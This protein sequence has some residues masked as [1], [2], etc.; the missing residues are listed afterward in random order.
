MRAASLSDTWLLSGRD[1]RKQDHN[2]CKG[3][4][5]KTNRWAK[6][7]PANSAELKEHYADR[8]F[9]EDGLGFDDNQ[10]EAR[11]VGAL[12]RFARLDRICPSMSRS[13]AL[14][15]GTSIRADNISQAA[16]SVAAV[17]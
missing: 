13:W 2:G 5:G 8:A 9:H 10:S 16:Q 15:A 17:P 14:W 11:Y 7:L 3:K 4:S 1:R 6:N 12:R